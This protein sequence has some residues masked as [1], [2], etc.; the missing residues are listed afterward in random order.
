MSP[1]LLFLSFVG[2]ID[3]VHFLGDALSASEIAASDPLAA[4]AHDAAIASAAV[5]G[6]LATT[7]DPAFQ[8]I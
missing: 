6:F 7:T 5:S 1:S 3:N 4:W 8:L 2:L